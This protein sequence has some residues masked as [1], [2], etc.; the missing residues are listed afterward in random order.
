MKPLMRGHQ[1]V[2]AVRWL[3]LGLLASFGLASCGGEER[4]GADRQ[5][6]E[7]SQPRGGPPPASVGTPPATSANSATDA[8]DMVNGAEDGTTVVLPP[9][10]L[11]LLTVTEEWNDGIVVEGAPDGSTH[12]AGATVAG[13]SGVTFTGIRFTD[14]VI[15]RTSQTGSPVGAR[16]IS[17]LRNEFAA[18]A[19]NACLTVRGARGVRII[20]NHMQGCRGGVEGPGGVEPSSNIEIRKNRIEDVVGDGIQFGHWSDVL[21]ADNQIL[22]ARDPEGV[23][24]NDSI[25]FLGDSRRVEILRNVLAGSTG[26]SI[27]IQDAVGGP[28]EDILIANNLIHGIEGYAVQQQG[29]ADTRIINNTIWDTKYGALLLRSGKSGPPARDTVVVNNIL[30]RYVEDEGA[31]AEVL[32]NNIILRADG[33]VPRERNLVGR[34]PGFL[35]PNDFRLGPGSPAVGAASQK[36]AP[37]LDLRGNDRGS[38]PDIGA[39]E[40]DRDGDN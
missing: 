21:I 15:V 33:L 4:S 3:A 30:D 35:S 23:I 29:A 12:L 37:E 24:H 16:S 14:E 9:G 18:P 11:P 17:F 36:Y 13:A 27:L 38:A 25:Q 2:L 26:Q 32:T 19:E 7:R 31:K 5:T 1:R 28:N 22:R 39:I 40:G 8:S 6:S 20:D 10:Q 34:P